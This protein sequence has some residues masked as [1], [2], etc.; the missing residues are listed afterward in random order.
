MIPNLLLSSGTYMKIISASSTSSNVIGTPKVLQTSSPLS[1]ANHTGIVQ[2]TPTTVTA[3]Q[4]QQ[5]GNKIAIRPAGI[6]P[7]TVRN[8][9]MSP[10][11]VMPRGSGP[12]ASGPTSIRPRLIGM[13]PG[14]RTISVTPSRQQQQQLQTVVIMNQAG[15]KQTIK[16]NAAEIARLTGKTPTGQ[17]Q[18]L[19]LPNMINKVTYTLYEYFSKTVL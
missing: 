16:V 17:P 19:T 4:P 13:Q 18:V 3:L 14:A 8:I 1:V 5:L 9:T 11:A 6:T 10:R 12:R 2:A 15:D 7:Q